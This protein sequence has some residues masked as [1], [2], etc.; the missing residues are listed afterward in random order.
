LKDKNRMKTYK[1]GYWLHIRDAYN[2]FYPKVW[3]NLASNLTKEDAN[4]CLECNPNW[5]MIEE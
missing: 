3:I 2:I 1:V 4:E 5:E